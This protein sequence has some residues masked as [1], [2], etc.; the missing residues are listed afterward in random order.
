MVRTPLAR[1]V[2]TEERL[3][4]VGLYLPYFDA[5]SVTAVVERL[6]TG[7]G[8][9]A[10][11]PVPDPLVLPAN[12]FVQ[13]EVWATIRALPTFTRPARSHRSSVARANAMATL[14]GKAGL[15][16]GASA[17]V[18]ARAIGALESIHS[19]Y[20]EEVRSQVEDYAT[21]DFTTRTV[22]WMTG[23][24]IDI[25]VET[26]RTAVR[27]VDD[28]YKAAC[29][30]LGDN[31][32]QLYRNHLCD[33]GFDPTDARLEEAAVAALEASRQAVESAML[34]LIDEWRNAHAMGLAELGDV[35]RAKFDHILAQSTRPEQIE[36]TL[37]P[38]ITVPDG[39][40]DWP[41]HIYSRSDGSYPESFNTWET[42]VLELEIAKTGRAAWYRNPSGGRRALGVP[43]Q[44]RD[45]SVHTMYPDFV[46]VRATE[47]GFTV[48]I[49]DPHDPSRSDTG[50]KWRGLASYASEFSDRVGR[51][52]AIIAD[53]DDALVA[54]DLRSDAIVTALSDADSEGDIRS[55]FAR[56]GGRLA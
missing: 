31:A 43:Y 25:T 34:N 19:T 7:E 36:L 8:A 47:G 41:S 13:D 38:S 51:V 12:P 53:G 15:V 29:R 9:V 14:L 20:R 3:N 18:A 26:Q 6:Q 40:G 11:S 37:P 49:L 48:D 16:P 45:G 39:K 56:F 32:G 5:D 30:R 27:N 50:P 24:T 44:E 33:E 1:R 35:S 17:V 28:L 54:V 4:E 10:S 42:R 23:R 22:E 52:L 46:F 2:A 55:I 21:V